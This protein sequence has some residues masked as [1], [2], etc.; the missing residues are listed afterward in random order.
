MARLPV[1]AQ[2]RENPPPE[3]VE[4]GWAPAS[5][6]ESLPTQ[7]PARSPEPSWVPS[8]LVPA[9]SWASAREYRSTEAVWELAP[10]P[11]QVPEPLLASA[12][13][14][15]STEV[16]EPA[17]VSESRAAYHSMAPAAREVEWT[18]AQAAPASP[19]A[20]PQRGQ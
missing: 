18:K 3:S 17:S 11:V 10:A 13:E 16:W 20:S 7:E 12:Q 2:G 19:S 8:A 9:S 6:W 15:Q 1:L 4:Q 5:E 14:Y